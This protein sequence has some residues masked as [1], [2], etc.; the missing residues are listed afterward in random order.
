MGSLAVI[1]KWMVIF[2]L[3]AGGLRA[4]DVS[5]YREWHEKC[6]ATDDAKVID[7]YIGRFQARFDADP[8]DQLAKVYLGSA[9]T[10]RS[11]AS[12]W[13]PKKLEY[14]KKGGRLMDEA[15]G[16][17]WHNPRVRF[18]RGANGYKV[19]KRFNRRPVAVEDF[20][21]LMPIAIKGGHGLKLRERQAMLYYAWRTFDEEGHKEMATQA[22][23]HCHQLDPSSWYGK[24]AGK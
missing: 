1:F 24:E 14:L 6:L 21:Y 11:A 5:D 7:G 15:A 19:P 20:T 9:Y 17:A 16:A 22:R 18:L 8:S 13:G 3:A 4:D 23:T 2:L 10:L 12:G